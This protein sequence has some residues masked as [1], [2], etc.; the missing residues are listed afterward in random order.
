MPSETTKGKVVLTF[1]TLCSCFFRTRCGQS[2]PAQR[3]D[4]NLY[5]EGM[6]CL[7]CLYPTS[8]TSKESTVSRWDLILSDYTHIRNCVLSN[9]RVT[10][11][12][13]IQ[14]YKFNSRTLTQWFQNQ[15]KVTETSVLQQTSLPTPSFTTGEQLQPVHSQVLV[16]QATSAQP[17]QF[18]L[19][20]NTSGMA[21][22]KKAPKIKPPTVQY[23]LI[24]PKSQ[25]VRIFVTL[26]TQK[27]LP[28]SLVLR[29][30]TV[31]LL[32]AFVIQNFVFRIQSV[33]CCNATGKK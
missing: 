25:M 21:G 22:C 15:E 5:V 27:K 17:Q 20:E 2:I 31:H 6:F 13:N 7:C 32:F 14:L 8:K 28:L 16:P 19:P 18:P 33:T 12:T 4:L 23:C 11:A 3:P 24:V 9:F 26:Q 29:T 1:L 30:Y 10:S